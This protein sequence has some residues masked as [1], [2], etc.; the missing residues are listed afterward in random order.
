MT[1]LGYY[2]FFYMS[3]ETI[4]YFSINRD[5]EVLVLSSSELLFYN[6]IFAFYAIILG[7][8]ATIHFL[9][10]RPFIFNRSVTIRTSIS[11]DQR[12][13][14]MSFVAWTSK[15]AFLISLLFCTMDGF[16]EVTFFQDFKYIYGLTIVVLLMQLWTS[17]IRYFKINPVKLFLSLSISM[18]ILAFILGSINP[19][20]FSKASTEVLKKNVYH[21]YE[22]EKPASHYWQ[23]KSKSNYTKD[24]YITKSKIKS[25]NKEIYYIFDNQEFKLQQLDSLV[26]F[27]KSRIHYSP[28]SRLFVRL[29][30]HKDIKMGDINPIKT[31]LL[32]S[33]LD[34]IGYAVI[35][36]ETVGNP[37]E[38]RKYVIPTELLDYE[39][40]EF[41]QSYHS[42]QDIIKI[43]VKN[44][45]C[46]IDGIPIQNQLLKDE[47]KNS[48][49]DKK[50]YRF[51]LDYSPDLSYQDFI[52]INSTIHQSIND[53]RNEYSHS[54][55]GYKY[56]Y[57]RNSEQREVRQLYPLNIEDNHY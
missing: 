46:I 9:V 17:L 3:R 48:I 8:S 45:Q 53:L 41:L 20:D 22:I 16:Y 7:I 42:K 31:Y 26:T 32:N 40:M 12:M 30:I 4:R 43:E 19:I 1:T 39:K 37:S 51:R 5:Y 21:N 44:D 15:I 13:L 36:I 47:I 10:D 38:F 50:N 29:N 57:L 55:Y 54:T 35:P 28:H 18:T 6:M 34:N 33:G 49:I 25:A 14:S 27:W 11:N 23:S 52:I 2:G 24:L 56:E